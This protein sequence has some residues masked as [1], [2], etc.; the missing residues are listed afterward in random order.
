MKRSAR[1]E[2]KEDF[3]LQCLLRLEEQS[4]IPPKPKIF[5]RLR[6][7]LSLSL[8]DLDVLT[9]KWQ[10]QGLKHTDN[11]GFRK[12]RKGTTLDIGRR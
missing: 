1:G 9:A 8:K 5:K 11:E 2:G 10:G 3:D 12:G 6:L 4:P 7:Q